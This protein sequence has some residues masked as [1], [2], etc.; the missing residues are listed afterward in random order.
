MPYH[1]VQQVVV[2][3][4]FAERRTETLEL[5]QRPLP[6]PSELIDAL[7]NSSRASF[8][9][10]RLRENLFMCCQI[11]EAQTIQSSEK[12]ICLLAR[13]TAI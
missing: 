12:T 5:T 8:F 7:Q 10:R 1:F 6:A 13:A 9:A 2:V 11:E 3:G 4:L